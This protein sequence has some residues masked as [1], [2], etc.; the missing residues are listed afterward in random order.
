MAFQL[1][2]NHNL[3]LPQAET[4]SHGEG[5]GGGT[6]STLSPQLQTLILGGDKTVT[7]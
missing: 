7:C 5:G 2:Q 6:L 3:S 1:G 4:A